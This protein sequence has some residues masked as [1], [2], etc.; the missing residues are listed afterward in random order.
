MPL[1]ELN[2]ISQDYGSVRVL[3]D[4]TVSLPTGKIGLL[5][6][7]GAGK[8]TLMKLLLG[9]LPPSQGSGT[10]LDIPLDGERTGWKIRQQVGYMPE[11][12][13]IVPGLTGVEYVSLAGQLCGMA[14]NQADRRAHEVLNYLELE[15]ARYRT[16]ETYSLGMK[17]RVKLAQA[18]IHDP[19]VL[20]LDEPT[21]GLDPAG[22]DTM[23]RLI[24]EL[25]SEHGKSILLCTHL[26]ADIRTVCD[27]VVV[28]VKGQIR[29]VGSVEELCARRDDHRTLRFA[30]DADS[31][32]RELTNAGIQIRQKLNA[33]TWQIQLPAPGATQLVF[34][35]A[36][37]SGV[38]VR[39]LIRD[40]ET[41]EEM[42]LKQ[43]QAVQSHEPL[44]FPANEKT[45]H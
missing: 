36:H 22:R 29:A 45:A 33:T 3:N 7:N 8:S 4:I 1:L 38:M 37:R 13:A 9:L 21:S 39:A 23:L 27:L 12:A 19:P 28:L 44:G 16:I 20:L 25:G 30:G 18:L 26:L 35:A 43:V 42:F 6:P 32:A 15:E 17:Q 5:G 41:L 14:K 10:M 11:A 24:H 2:H 34:S 40:D 31:L